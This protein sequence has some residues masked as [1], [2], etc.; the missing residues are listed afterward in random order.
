MLRSLVGS[1]MCI[2][3]S[4]SWLPPNNSQNIPEGVQHQYDVE[5]DGE[6]RRV[7][8]TWFTASGTGTLSI[9]V[10]AVIV[11]DT[12]YYGAW[13]NGS[14]IS[15][16]APPPAV[17]PSAVRFLGETSSTSGQI[18][19]VWVAP[20]QG[21]NVRYEYKLSTET[22]WRE[23]TDLGATISALDENTEYTIEVRPRND[24]GIGPTNTDNA[25]TL[26]RQVVTRPS[27]P[28]LQASQGANN[29]TCLL[30][31]SPSPRDS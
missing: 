26:Q 6:A 9:R 13:V 23:T 4:F 12:E 30:Y 21:E 15:L 5:F 17:A 25:R 1:E 27:V 24:V 29:Q 31:T 14:G 28:V 7:Q 8:R 16:T 22:E 19:W 11:S 2:R 18:T 10:R 3:D 20:L